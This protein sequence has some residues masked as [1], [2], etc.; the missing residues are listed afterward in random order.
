MSFQAVAP[1]LPGAGESDGS[2]G[3]PERCGVSVVWELVD[4][5]GGASGRDGLLL[6][7]V[8]Y[9]GLAAAKGSVRNGV[10]VTLMRTLL[11]LNP[12]RFWP[13]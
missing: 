6:A 7:A 1:G 3:R 12:F 9:E 5:G 4:A 10:T 11:L 8:S 13:S 2:A